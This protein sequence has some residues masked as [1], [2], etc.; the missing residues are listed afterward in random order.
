[1]P[2]PAGPRMPDARPDRRRIVAA[3]RRMIGRDQPRNIRSAPRLPESLTRFLSDPGAGMPAAR[4]WPWRPA[5]A[6]G[7]ARR[8]ALATFS[9]AT[10]SRATFSLALFAGICGPVLQAW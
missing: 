9:L 1:M 8:I 4:N 2:H 5:R 6:G 10:F 7:P 3:S